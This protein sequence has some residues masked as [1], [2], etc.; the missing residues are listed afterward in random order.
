MLLLTLSAE[1]GGSISAE[2]GLGVMKA[3]YVSYSQSPTSIDM[4]RR[5][6]TMF[7]PKGLLN[8]YKYIQ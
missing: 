3:P 5:I 8:P 2:H 7:D 1:K 4:M 6:K